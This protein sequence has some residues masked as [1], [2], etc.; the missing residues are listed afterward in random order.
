[1]RDSGPPVS[2]HPLLGE[3]ILPRSLQPLADVIEAILP[4][5]ER[6]Q[7]PTTEHLPGEGSPT[8]QQQKGYE[9][10]AHHPRIIRKPGRT[11]NEAQP[12]GGAALIQHADAKV[13][14]DL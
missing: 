11:G 6:H 7:P 1:M 2:P 12:T 5:P 14:H 8:C 4:R 9:D 13:D 10:R 3:G